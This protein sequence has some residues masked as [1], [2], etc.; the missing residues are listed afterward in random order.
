MLHDQVDM[1]LKHGVTN[2]KPK[3]CDQQDNIAFDGWAEHI[4]ASVSHFDKLEVAFCPFTYEFADLVY[5][6]SLTG[7]S[8]KRVAKGSIIEGLKE[9]QEMMNLCGKHNITCETETVT[10]A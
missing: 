1:Y 9:I 8:G 7:Q 6:L 10:P 5:V 2:E 4:P 3:A